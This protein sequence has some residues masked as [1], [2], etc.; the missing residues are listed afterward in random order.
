[1]NEN[2]TSTHPPVQFRGIRERNLDDQIL[3]AE[4]GYA[5]VEQMAIDELA[6]LY[7]ELRERV[8]VLESGEL[9]EI[10]GQG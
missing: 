5:S 6:K 1:M 2:S 4:G 7:H 8:E 9:P 10:E 3:V